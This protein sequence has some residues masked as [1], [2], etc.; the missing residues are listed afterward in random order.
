MKPENVQLKIL[1]I[2]GHLHVGGVERSL[3]N[4]LK[5]LD[6]SQYQ[7]DLLLLEDTGELLQ[8]VPP[9]VNTIYYDMKPT[10]GSVRTVVK[11]AVSNKNLTLASDKLVITAANKISGIFLRWLKLPR[12][13]YCVYDCVFAYRVGMPL[14]IAAY[15]VRA[16]K[17][18]VW[19]HN[20]SFDY[21]AKEVKKWNRAF[22]RMDRIICVSSS[23]MRMIE[24]FF[25]GQRKKIRILP[26]MILP[27]EILKKAEAFNPYGS[28]E[29]KTVLVS[30]GRLSA[31][32]HMIDTVEVMHQLR[33]R[34]F[35]ELVWYLVGDGPERS[36][37]ERKIND[38]G[39]TDFF[40]LVGNQVNPY[41]YIKRADIFVHPS[42][43]ESQGIV[44]LEAMMLEKPCVVVRSEGVNEFAIDGYNAVIS[45][46]ETD[47]LA[48]RVENVLL[49]NFCDMSK[50][51]RETVKAYFPAA[52]HRELFKIIAGSDS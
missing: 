50:G 38:Y 41:P 37:I 1:I 20:G 43:V 8:E 3:V 36:V 30:V 11:K 21:T 25:F 15:A 49:G 35:H 14:D 2:N 32:K 45:E 19:W 6:Y 48:Q 33:S 40:R 52:V 26:N 18:I 44:V 28:E 27:E 31:E 42:W 10:Y 13:L 51:Q 7:V 22:K 16:K 39:L 9:Q 47:D 24:P 5:T 12:E 4:L 17:R 23:V 34:G 46:K 29:S